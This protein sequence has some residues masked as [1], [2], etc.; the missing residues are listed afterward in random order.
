MKKVILL[1]LLIGGGFISNAQNIVYDENAEVRTVEKFNSLEVSGTLSLYLSQGPTQGV[2][3]SA[4]EE[5][6]NSKIKT[7]VKNGVLRISV[8]GGVWNGF[9]WT[10]RK[11]KAYVTV[12]DINRLDVSGASYASISGPLKSD[13]LKMD[14]SGA[15]EVKGIINVSR[16]NLDISGASV[17]RLSGTAKDGLIDASGACKVNSYELSIETCKA[18]SSGASN[19]KVTVTGELN[20]DASGGSNIYYK[21]QGIGK[22]LNASAGASIKNRSGSDD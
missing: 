9:N 20:A 2:A 17:A 21:G 7:E 12:T 5:K 10:N 8:D 11:L 16:L 19:I 4:G 14:I 15:S 13:E 3:I 18:S 22:V 6:Y 1:I